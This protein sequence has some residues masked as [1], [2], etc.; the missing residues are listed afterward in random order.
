[1]T[2]IP[3]QSPSTV[4]VDDETERLLALIQKR[5]TQAY[6]GV[7]KKWR[8]KATHYYSLYH[9]YTEWRNEM[10]TDRRDRDLGLRDAKREWGAELFIPYSFATVETI[11]GDMTTVSPSSFTP[12][13]LASGR[14]A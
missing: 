7:H 3:V 10:S 11:L 8:D 9:N 13:V 5:F 4:V 2:T 6:G 12:T 14:A 1:M